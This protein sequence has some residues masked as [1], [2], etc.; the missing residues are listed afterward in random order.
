[1]II[2]KSVNIKGHPRNISYYKD[3]GIII[4]VGKH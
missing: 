3:V 4:G 1:M 2:N